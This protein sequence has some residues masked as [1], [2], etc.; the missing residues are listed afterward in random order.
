VGVSESATKKRTGDNK[1]GRLKKENMF[2]NIKERFISAIAPDLPP[3]PGAGERRI[4]AGS[5]H[6]HNRL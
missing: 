1:G 4:G 2:S 5:G 3:L 6:L